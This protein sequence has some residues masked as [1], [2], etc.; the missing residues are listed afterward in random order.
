MNLATRYLGLDL[1]H[2]LVASSSPLSTSIDGINRLADAGASAIVLFSL[3]EEQINDSLESRES[4]MGK[5]TESLAEA[6]GYF[7]HHDEYA[8]SPDD[9]LE[10]I[11]KARNATN[12]PIVASIN[13]VSQEGWPGFLPQAVEAGASA[14]ELSIFF[15]PAGTHQS[16]Q[17]V[18]DRYV[19]MVRTA[20]QATD[21]PIAVKITPF[22]S[23]MGH[24]ARRLCEAGANGLVLFNRFYQPDFDVDDFVVQ[25]S[26]ELSSSTEMRLPL[27]WISILHKQVPCS[28][29]A[30]T[31]VETSREV[32][33]Y[34][35]AGADA[36]MVASALL[37]HGEGYMKTLRREL[38]EWAERKG[39]ATLGALKG[40]MSQRALADPSAFERANYLK[41]LQSYRMVGQA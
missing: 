18:E 1:E 2:P 33:K 32:V 24:F 40:T 5:A 10:L 23:S 34:V 12:V 22:F 41:V 9:Y 39:F 27:L 36:V 29:A 21:A 20:R 38:E 6:L 28:L 16:S 30:T 19:E 13:A 17:A 4:V 26:L 14:I 8:V 15:V 25:P 3:F 31:G 7:P 35:A 11:R 37:R